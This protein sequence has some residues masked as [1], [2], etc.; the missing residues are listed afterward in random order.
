M[1]GLT[2]EE[3]SYSRN[4]H[5]WAIN[6]YGDSAVFAGVYQRDD[7]LSVPDVFHELEVCFT[8]ESPGD[9]TT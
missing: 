7:L 2:I 5:F 3:R 4:V 1:A 8:F 9:G 6:A